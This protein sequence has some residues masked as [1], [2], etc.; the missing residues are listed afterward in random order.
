ME[1]VCQQPERRRKKVKLAPWELALRRYWPPVRL[2]LA[3][4]IILLILV[5][6]VSAIIG[7]FI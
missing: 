1:E 5:L 4:I 2:V 3:G 7:I 6:I